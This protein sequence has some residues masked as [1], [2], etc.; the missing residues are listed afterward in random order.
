MIIIIMIIIIIIIYIYIYI[1][2]NN[3]N[4]STIIITQCVSC[5]A[6][7]GLMP[8]VISCTCFSNL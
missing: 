6:A 7:A 4:N 3:H 2:C 5:E 1:Q 8:D